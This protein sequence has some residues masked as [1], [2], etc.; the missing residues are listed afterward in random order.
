MIKEFL[1]QTTSNEEFSLR[2]PITCKDG[3][4]MS[5]QASKFH[6]CSP[7]QNLTDG[8]YNS[9]EIGFPSEVESLLLKYAED[10][11]KPTGTVYGYVPL[12]VV[13]SVIEKHGGI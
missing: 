7:R 6:Y 12:N 4:T 10:P 5:V 3:F 9:V 13:D 11:E 8:N 1:K 2:K